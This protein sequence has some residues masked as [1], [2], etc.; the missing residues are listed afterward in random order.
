[1]ADREVLP[2]PSA[3][4]IN[5]S[6]I[7]AVEL[8]S[9]A[10]SNAPARKDIPADMVTNVSSAIL[11]VGTRSTDAEPARSDEKNINTKYVKTGNEFSRINPT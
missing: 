3:D 6:V 4:D 2:D 11:K 8:H 5:S 7:S 9:K 10:E 1:M